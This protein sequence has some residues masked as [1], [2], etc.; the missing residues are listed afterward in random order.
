MCTGTAPGSPSEAKIVFQAKMQ[1]TARQQGGPGSALRLGQLLCL[2]LLAGH[3]ADRDYLPLCPRGGGGLVVSAPSTK[4]A[5]P[6]PC[7]TQGLPFQFVGKE[8]SRY[9]QKTGVLQLVRELPK[10]ESPDDADS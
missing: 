6:C 3:G 9:K 10:P 1:P 8:N 2:P 7:G 4:R 5:S